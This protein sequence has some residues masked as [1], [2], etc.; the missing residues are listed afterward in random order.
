MSITV[1]YYRL[2]AAERKRVTS[3]ESDWEEFRSQIDRAYFDSFH[4]AMAGLEGFAGTTEERFAKMDALLQEGRD[5]HR[6]DLEKDWQIVGYLLTG[7]ADIVEQH[8]N[9]DLL[10]SS[11]FGGHETTITTGYGPVR[12]Y[13]SHLVAETAKTFKS[14]DDEILA[15]RFDPDRMRKLS[16]YAAPEKAE[17]ETIFNIVK[18]FT[19]FFETTAGTGEDIIKFVS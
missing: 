1:T 14:I 3:N 15:K 17:R 16:I 19:K 12:F 7:R 6:F 18:S 8:N 5:P 11:I 2:P 10:Y 13:D 4:K 9:S